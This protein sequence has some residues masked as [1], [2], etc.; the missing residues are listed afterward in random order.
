MESSIEDQNVANK[1]KDSITIGDMI[2]SKRQYDYLFSNESLKRHGLKDVVARWP[3]AVV[4]VKFGSF[5]KNMRKRIENAMK[6]ISGVSCIN[7]DVKKKD[8]TNY[9]H[10][11]PRKKGCSSNLGFLNEGKQKLQLST[12]CNKGSIVH[13]LLVSLTMFN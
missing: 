2:L 12:H 4:T 11:K 5:K 13:E 1:K 6:Y 3:D 8:L 7:F 9:V 10:I